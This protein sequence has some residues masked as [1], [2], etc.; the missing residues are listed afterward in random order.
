MKLRVF[1]LCLMLFMAQTMMAQLTSL[2]GIGDSFST[3]SNSKI[4]FHGDYLYAASSD[5]LYRYDL[6]D[7]MAGWQ[8][9]V[10]TDSLVV[11]FEV[12][13]DTINVLTNNQLCTSVDG[14]KTTNGISIDAIYPYWNKREFTGFAV[15]PSNTNKIHVALRCGLFYTDDGG[16]TWVAVDSLMEIVDLTYNPLDEKNLIGYSNYGDANIYVSTDGG[17]IWENAKGYYISS[18]TCESIAFHPTDKN[19]IMMCGIGNYAISKDQGYTWNTIGH[20]PINPDLG[21]QPLVHIEYI[22]YDP[23]NPNILYGADW[24]YHQDGK[25]PGESPILRSIDGGFSWDTFYTIDT[26]YP[27]GIS[28]MSMKDNMLAICPRWSNEVLLLDV[29]ALESSISSTQS[30]AIVTPYYDLMGRPVAHPT[31]GIYIKDGRKVVIVE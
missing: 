16:K 10:T 4:E 6:N 13:G 18:R 20:E 28:C 7:S 17:F 19:R 21:I 31:R 29:D 1:S 9:I 25:I 30:D 27:S 3:P 22:L 2:G 26:V 5:G 23:R 14:G 15:H 12:R 8:K 24:T 11:D